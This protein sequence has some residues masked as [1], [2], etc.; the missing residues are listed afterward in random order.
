MIL[1]LR[2]NVEAER[3]IRSVAVVQGAL[4]V[5]AFAALLL[6]FARSDMS[7]AL[8][9]EN[10]HT[11]KPFIYKVAGAW[12]EHEG[13]MLVWVAILFLGG[14]S[15]SFVFRRASARTSIAG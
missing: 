9:F 2:T 3:T 14:A 1:A 15:V 11:A 5:I 6:V 12:G 4:T 8:V 13:S 10:S 7:V